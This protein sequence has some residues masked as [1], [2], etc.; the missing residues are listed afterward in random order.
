VLEEVFLFRQYIGIGYT[1]NVSDS[2]LGVLKLNRNN[3]KNYLKANG[4]WF[5]EPHFAYINNNVSKTKITLRDVSLV[6]AR[7]RRSNKILWYNQWN[8][9]EEKGLYL[10]LSKNRK[11]SKRQFI[12]LVKTGELDV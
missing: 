2:F 8:E 10:E 12:K 4:W 1:E 7:D 3:M 11:I 6:V 5:S 9:T